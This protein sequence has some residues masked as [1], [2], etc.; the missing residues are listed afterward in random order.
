MRHSDRPQFPITRLAE[1]PQA[2]PRIVDPR[3]PVRFERQMTFRSPNPL[4]YRISELVHGTYPGRAST[5]EILAFTGPAWEESDSIAILPPSEH[6]PYS[7]RP[8]DATLPCG[9]VIT[10][11]R[12]IF[13]SWTSV[14]RIGVGVWTSDAGPRQT[15]VVAFALD[16]PCSEWNSGSNRYRILL[17]SAMPWR[18]A[19]LNVSLHTPPDLV[20]LSEAEIG[21]PIT[22]AIYNLR[23]NA[24]S[25]RRCVRVRHGFRCS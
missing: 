17:E 18:L 15:L 22:F 24:L 23:L 19:T 5:G 4:P 13:L 21:E 11:Y 20:V 10:G 2:L 25:F 7:D 16:V 6:H 1:P 3:S 14:H 9:P 8:A 12:S